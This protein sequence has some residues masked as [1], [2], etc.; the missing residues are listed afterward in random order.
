LRQVAGSQE[1]YIFP[2]GL[3]R[4][5]VYLDALLVKLSKSPSSYSSYNKSVD[6]LIVQRH[7]RIA[8]PMYMALISVADSRYTFRFS[9]YYNKYGS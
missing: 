7:N 4:G 3:T 9:V 6:M 5:P 8:G 1:R 2:D